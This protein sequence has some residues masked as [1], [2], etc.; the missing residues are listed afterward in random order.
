L[1]FEKAKN[2]NLAQGNHLVS[3]AQVV[4]FKTRMMSCKSSLQDLEVQFDV[5][6]ENTTKPSSAP[7]T[8]KASTSNE[9]ERYYNI[10]INALCAQSQHSNVEQVLV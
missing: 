8:I 5:L 7:K 1:K 2:K 3:R 9:C 4:L 6:W 10:D